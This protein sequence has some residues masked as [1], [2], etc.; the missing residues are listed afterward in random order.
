M[1]AA[2]QAHDNSTS[3]LSPASSPD[4]PAVSLYL[5]LQSVFSFSGACAAAAYASASR[6]SAARRPPQL[7]EGRHTS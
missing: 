6:M 5:T 4:A 7:L 1:R 2:S 3:K